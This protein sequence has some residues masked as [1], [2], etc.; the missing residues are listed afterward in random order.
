MHKDWKDINYSNY[1]KDLTENRKTILGY[2]LVTQGIDLSQL[3][4]SFFSSFKY[5]ESQKSNKCDMKL[6]KVHIVDILGTSYKDY[7]SDEGIIYSFMKLKRIE[8]YVKHNQFTYLKLS[9]LLKSSPAHPSLYVQLTKN[10]DG[11]YFVDGQGNHRVIMYKMLMLCEIHKLKYDYEN[12]SELMSSEKNRYIPKELKK[13]WIYALV[14][15]G[16]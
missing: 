13:Y 11:K 15:N 5:F 2:A 6:E 4:N 8:D 16:Q 10:K 14:R 7:S 12:L 1:Y 3:P 9:R